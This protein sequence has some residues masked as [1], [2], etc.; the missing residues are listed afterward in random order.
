M[1][2]K[3]TEFIHSLDN[4]STTIKKSS[5]ICVLCRGGKIL[6]YGIN[7]NRTRVRS[8]KYLTNEHFLSLHAEFDAIRHYLNRRQKKKRENDLYVVRIRKDGSFSN[9]KPC[10]VCQELIQ[11]CGIIKRVFYSYE[12]GFN[13]LF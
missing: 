5:H 10:E 4:I 12:G 2:K 13:R 1:I 6:C 11:R 8:L 9:S 7:S 3:I